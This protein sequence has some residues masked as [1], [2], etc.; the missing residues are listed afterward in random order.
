MT[1]AVCDM[2]SEDTEGQVIMWRCLNRVMERNDLLNPNFK[3]FMA[4]SAQ[5]NWN[6]V[7]IVYGSG[8][9]SVKMIDRERT[10]LF[11]WATSLKQHTE[12]LIKRDMQCQHMKLCRDY[13]DAKTLEEAE[14][15]YL[16]IKAW[17]YSSGA[18]SEDSL[19]ELELWLAFWHFRYRQWGGFMETVSL[20]SI[21]FEYGFLENVTLQFI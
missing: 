14:N 9:P 20:T 18:A 16:Q 6:A 7:R 12:R 19:K 13:K 15:K 4:D 10:C 11:H 2:Q 3:G 5:A 17:W 1:I 21:F 8:D